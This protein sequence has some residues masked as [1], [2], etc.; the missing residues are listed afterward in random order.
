ME[1]SLLFLSM[2]FEKFNQ[3]WNN[4]SSAPPINTL[5]R[6][7]SEGRTVLVT[8]A[9]SGLGLEAARHYVQLGASKV[10]LAVRTA[11]KGEAAREDIERT[12]GCKGVVE[13]WILSYDSI[14]SIEAFSSRIT[15]EIS[16]LDIVLL[17]AGVSKAEFGVSNEGWEE[18]IQ[19]NV[20]STVRLALLLLPKLKDSKTASWTP[21]LS[22]VSSIGHKSVS[23]F[24]GQNAPNILKALNEPDVFGGINFRYMVSKLLLVYAVN[25]IGKLALSSNGE[26][27]VVVTYSC[28][29]MTRSGI[30]RDFTGNPILVGIMGILITSEEG[31]VLQKKVWGEVLQVIQ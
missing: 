29:D 20:L 27:L 16:S 12:T 15:S 13:V 23:S 17:N 18:T 11:S 25:E 22:F 10:I 7:L 5:I 1:V 26:V 28:L 2:A 14:A 3:L 24:P 21:R 8:G 6:N 4:G 9:N 19:V 31:K 30:A